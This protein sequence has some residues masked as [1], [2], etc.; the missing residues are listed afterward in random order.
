MFWFQN[1]N[2][3]R[4]NNI[5]TLLSALLLGSLVAGPARASS[6]KKNTGKTV[7]VAVFETVHSSC[8]DRP[9]INNRR[10][11]IWSNN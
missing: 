10:K 1:Q 9:D 6:V 2:L 8:E 7:P 5:S 4:M 3:S 11:G